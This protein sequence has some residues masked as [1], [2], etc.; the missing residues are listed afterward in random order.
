MLGGVPLFDNILVLGD[1]NIHF[2]CP[3]K[4]LVNGHWILFSGCKGLH[5]MAI[6]WIWFFHMSISPLPFTL[7]LTGH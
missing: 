7:W 4:P 3:T 2:C 1:F 5:M 6:Y